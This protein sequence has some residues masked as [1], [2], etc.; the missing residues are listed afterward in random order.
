MSSL[1]EGSKVGG[2]RV[3][4]RLNEGGMAT[5]YLA[6]SD[7]RPDGPPV[8]LKVLQSRLAKDA[9][10]VRMFVDEALISIRI[11]H[12]NVVR[13]DELGDAFGT[14]YLVM[15]YIHGASLSELLR[16]LARGGRALRPAVAAAIAGRVADG[17]HG[18]H[19]TRSEDG[20][21]LNVVHRDVS[22][23]NVL[24]SADG[25]V[26]L[27]DFGIAKAR[28]RRERTEAGVI[29]GKVRYM[30]PEQARGLPLDR[31]TDIYAL[32]VVLW[33]MLT[34][35]R[36]VARG[37]DNEVIERV[38]SPIPRSARDLIPD[39]P[40]E[41]D[42]VLLS[43]L[44]PLPENRPP[45]AQ[46]FRE[47]LERAIPMRDVE[48]DDLAELLR[49]VLGPT[50]LER[51]EALPE[52]LRGPLVDRLSTPDAGFG[53]LSELEDGATWVR[54]LTTELEP[55]EGLTD[56]EEG[57]EAGEP[58]DGPPAGDG[59]ERPTDPRPQL[60]RRSPAGLPAH[61]GSAEPASVA[62]RRFPRPGADR[63]PPSPWTGEGISS[64][65]P[66]PSRRRILWLLFALAVLVVASAVVAYANR[67]A[68][69]PRIE[70]VR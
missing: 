57:A 28:G 29:K 21:I 19:E 1:R 61:F 43:A 31:R 36:Y 53:D 67:A 35:H 13:V 58:S 54:T 27:L 17:L 23:Q 70:V 30:A 25:G 2:Y 9:Q 16:A 68:E 14:P 39:L 55:E 63:V 47:A 6:R 50:L 26:R 33:E 48:D 41:L 40:V 46:A 42:E 11:R 3:L 62:R 4:S 64:S 24:L 7:E 15:E 22:P 34:V 12:P 38:R 8:A 65:R 10:F 20:E 32:G 51:A 5:L 69:S 66:P 56:D 52:S 37:P 49:I 60:P 18:A 59:D 45:T 44:A